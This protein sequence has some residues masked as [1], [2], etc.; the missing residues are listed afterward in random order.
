MYDPRK[1]FR[2]NLNKIADPVG[3]YICIARYKKRVRGID[4]YVTSKS[5]QA[6]E[7]GGM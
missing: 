5:S 3:T 4:Y 7:Y 1:G 6:P 2:V